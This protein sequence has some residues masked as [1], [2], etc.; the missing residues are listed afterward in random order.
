MAAAGDPE[1][2]EFSAA[3]LLRWQEAGCLLAS[4][5]SPFYAELFGRFAQDCELGDPPVARLLAL[6]PMTL[7][8][9]SP[10]RLFGGVQRGLLAGELPQLAT[11]WPTPERASGDV[12]GAYELLQELFASPSASVL[13]ALTRDPQTNEVGRSA[14]LALGLARVGRV[15]AKPIR[16]FEIGSSA[17]LNLRIDSYFYDGGGGDMGNAGRV[18]AVRPRLLRPA[19]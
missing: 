5:P 2:P 9:A 14:A 16:L 8:A 17:G 13:D 12:D 7:N 4:S 3:E 11:T 6:A 10:L 18:S 15:T 19:H 1:R